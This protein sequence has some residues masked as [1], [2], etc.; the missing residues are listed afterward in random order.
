M[1]ITTQSR[2]KQHALLII[3]LMASVVGMLAGPKTKDV[4]PE[5]AQRMIEKGGYLVLDVRTMKEY[6]AGHLVNAILI[7]WYKKDFLDNVEKLDKN[8]PVIVYCA[9]GRRSAWAMDKMSEHGFKEVYNVLGGF[10]RW[11]KESLPSVR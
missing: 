1:T 7:D 2:M 5:Q 10:E 3:V 11:S 4:T 8:K 9:R 6:R